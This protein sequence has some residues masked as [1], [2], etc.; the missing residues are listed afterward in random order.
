MD[1][2]GSITIP[3]VMYASGSNTTYGSL[4]IYGEK[5]GW[6]G[7]NFRDAAGNNVG[8]LMMNASYSGYFNSADNAWRW[9]VDNTGNSYQPGNVEASTLQP[10]YVAVENA[11]C[12]NG[13]SDNGKIA[14]DSVGLT[15]S[16]QSG[17]WKKAGGTSGGAVKF[18]G[19]WNAY[20]HYTG[21][22]VICAAANIVTGG[23]SCPA[24]YQARRMGIGAINYTAGL[25]GHYSYDYTCES[26]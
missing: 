10:F 18:G 21:S 6:S 2:A 11:A 13:V 1:A 24:G 3:G 15:L 7:I 14:R 19:S 25:G 12:P 5:N 23:C 9:R 4:T 16:C 26:L 22:F 17:V 20:H 8:T